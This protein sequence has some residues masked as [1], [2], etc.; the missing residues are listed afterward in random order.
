MRL[1]MLW[2]CWVQWT[3]WMARFAGTPGAEGWLLAEMTSCS[4]W[5]GLPLALPP[6]NHQAA[7]A[8]K[9]TTKRPTS[10]RALKDRTSASIWSGLMPLGWNMLMGDPPSHRQRAVS[11]LAF[12]SPAWGASEAPSVRI[13]GTGRFRPPSTHRRGTMSRRIPLFAA[14]VAAALVVPTTAAQAD[15]GLTPS[16]SPFTYGAITA[17][18]SYYNASTPIVLTNN[19]GSDVTLSAGVDTVTSSNDGWSWIVVGGGPYPNCVSLSLVV[20][21]GD[22]CIVIPYV[23]WKGSLGET[24]ATLTV[25]SDQGT[26]D[27]PVSANF[28]ASI[29]D[30]L[31]KG[32]S[33]FTQVVGAAPKTHTF[34]VKNDGNIDLHT[35]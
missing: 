33:W 7:N 17:G 9:M 5:W 21:A 12:G 11:A 24:T 6:V 31:P 27:I 28:Q 1:K 15:S 19:T 25:H 23:V 32:D 29:A 14:L 3:L 8:A 10:G 30:Y 16:V 4:A 2:P 20:A 34:F 35:T 26:T 18:Q 22:S 13:L